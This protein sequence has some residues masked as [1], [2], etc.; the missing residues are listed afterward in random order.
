MSKDRIRRSGGDLSLIEQSHLREA[1]QDQDLNEAARILNE[2]ALKVLVTQRVDR[3]EP[4]LADKV[5][6]DAA[7]TRQIPS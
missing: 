6:N 7:T 5:L 1:S 2:Q 3:T 4:T